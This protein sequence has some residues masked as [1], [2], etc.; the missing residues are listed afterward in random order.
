LYLSESNRIRIGLPKFTSNGGVYYIDTLFSNNL[1]LKT[2]FNYYS[3]GSRYEQRFDYEKGISSSYLYDQINATTYLINRNEF[4]PSF[5]LD[6]FLAGRIQDSAIIYFTW[7][8]L[9]DA[10]Y[11]IVPYYPLYPRGLRFGVAWEFLD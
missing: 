1:K 7:E 2:G 9:L 4:T 6:F 11:S 8:N 10:R 3:Y 5:Q